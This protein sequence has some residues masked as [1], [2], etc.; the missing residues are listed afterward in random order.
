MDDEFVLIGSENGVAKLF[1][2]NKS[3]VS[4]QTFMSNA[5]LF[6]TR[7]NSVALKK[8]FVMIGYEDNFAVI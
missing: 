2:R 6:N 1:E 3:F 7:I 5:D 4:C 8:G